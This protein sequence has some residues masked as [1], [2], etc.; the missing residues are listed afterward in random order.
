MSL[1]VAFLLPIA[2][3]RAQQPAQ[4][5]PDPANLEVQKV[6]ENVYVVKGGGANS[7]VFLTTRAA[8]VV[9]MK[10]PGWGTALLTKIASFTSLPV[11]TVI[12][13]HS[14]SDHVGGNAELPPGVEVVTHEV[15]KDQ[16]AKMPAFALFSH[17][18]G[19]SVALSFL[20]RYQAVPNAP[21]RITHQ[22]I[23]NG[24]KWFWDSS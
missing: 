19:D 8:I 14:H 21:F 6:K 23:T 24:N 17:D 9:D 20:Q 16:M 5:P 1:L 7:T 2:V 18:R 3:A 13:T 4:P 15:A 11:T 10:N 22:F 12:N